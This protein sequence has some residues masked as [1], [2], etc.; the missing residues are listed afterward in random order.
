MLC[1]LLSSPV[2]HLDLTEH[3]VTSS[4]LALVDGEPR[5][6]HQQLTDPC[7]LTLLTFKDSDPTLVNQVRVEKETVC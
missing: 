6:L 2:C 7:S 3:H 4:A 5:S 1:T